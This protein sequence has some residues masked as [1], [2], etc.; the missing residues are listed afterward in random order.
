MRK[1]FHLIVFKILIVLFAGCD[2]GRPPADDPAGASRLAALLRGEPEAGYALADRPRDFDFP[3]DHGPH[4][5]FRNEWWYVT[6]NLD[7]VDGH[8]YGYELTLF[9]FGLAP[10]DAR[11]DAGVSQWRSRE[12]FVG[13]FALTDVRARRFHVA[14]RL[15]RGA[16]GLAGA[17]GPP[18]R[19]WLEDWSLS[20]Q[21]AQ[22]G[23]ADEVGAPWLLEAAHEDL[24]VTLSLVPL[25]GPVLNG[26]AGLSRKSAEPGNA[27]YYYS[28][29]RLATSGTLVV[30][31]K[32]RQVT[33]VSWLD[34][35]WGSR[36]LSE[37]QEGWDW[38]ALQLDDG[39]NLMFYQLRE[40]DGTAH[41]MSAG[42][43]MPADG[44]AVHLAQDEVAI[45]V[46]DHWESPRGGRY[47]V[48][49]TLR[50]P[51]RDL[52]LEVEPVIEAQELD[53]N[54]RYWEGAVD[55]TGRS[56]GEPI[57]GRGYVE[58]TGYAR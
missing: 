24:A 57:D 9:R 15:S 18:V 45:E 47:P 7:D 14:E 8:R 16:L 34:R 49:W 27:S 23:E 21:P 28:M 38:F 5:D 11:D 54:V 19:V 31:G 32:P 51:S 25:R 13:H 2:A 53:T 10:P 1:I 37:S 46:R 44:E 39:S 6:G 52:V 58:L 30:D 36:G 12:V 40:L 20:Q 33:G 3:A 29:P 22:G 35:E 48:S 55:V 43:W 50:I 17:S 26:I 41:E 56:E 42:T 4:R